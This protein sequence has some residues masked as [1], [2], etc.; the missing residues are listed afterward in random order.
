[1][2]VRRMNVDDVPQVVEIDKSSFTLPWTERAFR[3]E[4]SENA[5]SRCWVVEAE[6]RKVVAMLVLW[7]ILDEAHI[8]TIATHPH[9]R[10]RGYAKRMLVEAL[11]E[12]RAEGANSA[13]LEV[14]A[15]HVVA[16]K[17]YHDLGFV[18]VGQRAHYY[19]D[20]GEDAILMTLSPIAGDWL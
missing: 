10:R 1:M 4:V 6:D 2:I 5:A 3:Y 7:M 15:R 17:I 11:K 20:N 12:A 8:A 13:L 18:D 16:Q 14:R 9:Y 19:R